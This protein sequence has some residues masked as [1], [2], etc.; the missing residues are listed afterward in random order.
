MS[1]ILRPILV[2][3]VFLT[4]A[5][6]AM[7]ATSRT[8]ASLGYVVTTSTSSIIVITESG[9]VVNIQTDGTVTTTNT[10]Y[11]T[12]DCTGTTYI[13]SPVKGAVYRNNGNYYKIKNVAPINTLQSYRRDDG[14]CIIYSNA[15]QWGTQVDAILSTEIPFTLPVDMPISISST[16]KV[17]VIPLN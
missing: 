12:T 3:L 17:V 5:F 7:Q 10:R 15:D 2:I 11:T 14:T 4:P 16:P 9:Q 8:G 6:S 1:V 13:I